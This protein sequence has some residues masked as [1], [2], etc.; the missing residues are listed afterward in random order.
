MC[1]CSDAEIDPIV[2]AMI[3]PKRE[4]IILPLSTEMTAQE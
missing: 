1:N 2:S 4:K 3:G